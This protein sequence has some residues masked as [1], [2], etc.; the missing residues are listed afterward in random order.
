MFNYSLLDWEWKWGWIGRGERGG[1]EWINLEPNGVE[2]FFII[3]LG[4]GWLPAYK[5]GG[6]WVDGRE[7]EREKVRV[8]HPDA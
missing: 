2:S 7:R 1:A 3:Q 4:G 6:V 5:G 8:D